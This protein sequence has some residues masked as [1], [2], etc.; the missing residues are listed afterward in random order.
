MKKSNCKN[1]N[2][3][4]SCR[5]FPSHSSTLRVLCGSPSKRVTRSWLAALL[6]LLLSSVVFN[7]ASALTYQNDTDVDFT[8]NPTISMTVSGDLIIDNLTPGS[9]SDSNIITVNAATNAS[10]GYYLVATVGTSSTNA[11]LNHSS[12]SSYKFTNLTTNKATLSGFDDNQWGYSYSTDNGANWVSGSQGSTDTG[13]NGLPLDGNDSGATGITLIDT[14]SPVANNSVKFKIGAKAS[15]TQPSGT[16]TNT[17]NFYAVTHQAP[18]YMQYVS[19]ST[20]ATLMPNVNDST[21]LYDIRDNQEY[22][23]TKLADGKYWMTKNL[24]IA[25]GTALSSVDTDVDR[26]YIDN[27]TTSNNLTKTNNTIVLPE[28]STTGFNTNNYS[29]VYNTGNNTDNC[30]D[31]GC[32]SYYSWDAATLGSGRSIS[33]D[34]TDAPY[35]IC[36]KGW[37]LPTS[38][39]HLDNGWKR[40]DFYRLATAYGVNLENT[41]SNAT[42]TFYNNA[43]PNTAANFLLDGYYINS[44]FYKG[45]A[46]GFIWSS[47]SSDNTNRA[48]YLAFSAGSVNSASRDDRYTGF[49]IRC[50]ARE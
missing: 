48:H 34:N 47:T 44:E 42:V 49:S 50:L 2:M 12:N 32:Y 20:L 1:N 37:K 22:T 33:T 23:V 16:Y 15:N 17:I 21:I 25:G 29:Y 5:V 7:S 4:G 45:K 39:N 10:H 28:S 8:I 19:S 11:N 40:G 26:V 24:N 3:S 31:P 41:Y 27:F 35:S 30:A 36:P 14:T 18:L 46:S 38:G 13:Y 6:T 43:G 9:S